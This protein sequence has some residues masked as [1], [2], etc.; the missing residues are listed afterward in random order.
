MPVLRAKI[1]LG[2]MQPGQVLSVLSTD[3]HS[4][5]DFRAYCRHTGNELLQVIESSECF[6]FLIRKVQP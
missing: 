5:P 2:A 1:V 3:P 6:E 4:L